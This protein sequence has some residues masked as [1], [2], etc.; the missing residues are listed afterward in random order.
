[1]VCS[2]VPV[3]FAAYPGIDSDLASSSWYGASATSTVEAEYGGPGW[4]DTGTW[5][6]LIYAP[7]PTMARV[8]E[9]YIWWGIDQYS[10]EDSINQDF[11][12]QED[13]PIVA[14]D[15]ISAR[16]RAQV[17]VSGHGYEFVDSGTA[18]ADVS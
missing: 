15:Y 5:G 4:Y 14:Y 12:T 2:I 10:N 3:V 1:M 13:F 18:R 8:S 16:C 7:S 6:S 17:W 11:I 9:M